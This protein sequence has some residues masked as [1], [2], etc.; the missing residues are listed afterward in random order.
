MKGSQASSVGV[1]RGSR[2]SLVCFAQVEAA[3]FTI[4]DKKTFVLS[5]ARASTFFEAHTDALSFP[6][7]VRHMCSGPVCGIVVARMSAVSV[8]QQLAGPATPAEAASY[9][10]SLRALYARDNQRNAVHVS[11]SEKAARSRASSGLCS[12]VSEDAKL[13]Y[14]VRIKRNIERS[15]QRTTQQLNMEGSFSAVSKPFFKL[16]QMLI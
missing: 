11:M 14:L 5:E 4:L 12:T 6:S 1:Q 7:L 16:K 13:D 9:P 3:N 8:L 15:F 2:V 10:T